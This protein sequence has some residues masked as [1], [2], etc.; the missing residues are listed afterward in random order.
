MKKYFRLICMLLSVAA[1]TA[2]TDD[3]RGAV[4][5]QDMSYQLDPDYIYVD[6]PEEFQ[7]DASNILY[8]DGK[9]VLTLNAKHD[10][11][12]TSISEGT[13]YSFT[14][15]MKKAIEKDLVVSLTYDETLLDEFAAGSLKLFPE[16]TVS[17]PDVT[18]K[19]GEKE[20]TATL[21]LQNL[22]QLNEVPGYILPLR[23]EIREA[24]NDV[25]VSVQKYSVF[26]Q[27]NMELAKD[28][29][30]TSSFVEFEAEKFNDIITF[31]ASRS[32][33]Y[34]KYL[35]DGYESG[36]SWYGYSGDWL[37][38]T[39]PVVETVKGIKLILHN[40]YLLGHLKIS[41][42]EGDGFV[43]YGAIDFDQRD[44]VC[45]KFKEPVPVKAIKF[46]EFLCVGGR[47]N[48]PELYEIYFLR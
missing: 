19:A 18:M 32:T 3:E 31:N 4:V 35:N 21:N 40:S 45:I 26:V 33:N 38:M 34:L 16:T 36:S 9:T 8:L 11:T 6:I 7:F 37:T 20:V 41:V 13:E 29:I 12:N 22:E 2:C 47:D 5:S 48:G 10:G 46:E 15:R 17:L 28:N 42:D 44:Y 39:L 1:F 27:L 24:N 25:K 14:I 23:L 43:S 30:D